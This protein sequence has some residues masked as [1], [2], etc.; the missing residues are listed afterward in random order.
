MVLNPRSQE[1]FGGRISAA[2]TPST[3]IL[4]NVFDGGPKTTVKYRIDDGEAKSMSKVEEPDPHFVELQNRF[5]ASMKSWVQAFPS[6]HLW[7]A[8]LDE[9]APGT[10]VLHVEAVDEFS[11]TH[12]AS[13]VLEI[14]WK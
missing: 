1:L 14:V 7:S 11:N 9:L 8:A 10:Y 13:K 12:R 2:H 3:R 6:Q 4:V 5:S